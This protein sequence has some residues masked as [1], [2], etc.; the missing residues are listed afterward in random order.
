MAVLLRHN[1][2]VKPLCGPDEGQDHYFFAAWRHT[3]DALSDFVLRVQ[4]GTDADYFEV[5]ARA[6][7]H[8]GRARHDPALRRYLWLQQGVQVDLSESRFGRGP[9]HE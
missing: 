7:R 6:Q 5:A 1:T 3:A 9:A 8:G 4:R 2:Q